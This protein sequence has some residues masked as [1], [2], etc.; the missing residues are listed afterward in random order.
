MAGTEK[1][2]SKGSSKIANTGVRL[3]ASDS[4]NKRKLIIVGAGALAVL[5]LIVTVV[6]LFSTGNEVKAPPPVGCQR[7][8]DCSDGRFC[9]RGGCIVLMS[10]EHRGI[11]LDAIKAQTAPGNTWRADKEVGVLLGAETICPLPSAAVP[12]PRI[13]RMTV[14]AD[15]HVLEV[16][17][18]DIRVHLHRQVQGE[19]WVD[20]L[21]FDLSA[22][23]PLDSPEFCGTENVVGI[24]A[25]KGASA[26]PRADILLKSAAPAGKP[27]AAGISYKTAAPS[28]NTDG[29][30]VLKVAI[31][32]P[33]LPG[34]AEHTMVAFPLGTDID[35]ISGPK[36][37][38]QKLVKGFVLYDFVH[39][40]SPTTAAFTYK[41]NKDLAASLDVSSESLQ[42]DSY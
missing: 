1:P 22:Y 18:T 6:I 3:G 10:S 27:V 42:I 33:R 14:L 29:R 13:N 25:P 11:W 41:I 15:V 28:S 38:R 2:Y 34:T 26:H 4:G 16:G 31:E 9:A 40:S 19:V 12:N 21:R 23:P 36:P 37:A 39:T 32:A 24:R 30:T 20:A 35:T 5:A 8:A 7:D 17:D